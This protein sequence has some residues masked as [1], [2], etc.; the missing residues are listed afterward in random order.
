M[1][2]FLNNTSDLAV[3]STTKATTLAD[4]T[5]T[6]N[7]K[8]EGCVSIQ[9]V[10]QPTSVVKL[11]SNPKQSKFK[12]LL[13][14]LHL[15][16][17]KEKRKRQARVYR[18]N[19]FKKLKDIFNK[20]EDERSRSMSIPENNDYDFSHIDTF[21]PHNIPNMEDLR[22]QVPNI[23][24]EF[25]LQDDDQLLVKVPTPKEITDKMAEV[26]E[27][28][29]KVAEVVEPKPQTE[30]VTTTSQKEKEETTY[31]FTIRKFLK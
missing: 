29:E 8:N 31:A 12:K 6:N 1:A 7:K 4:V 28:S 25:G 26:K 17:Y 19:P 23:T 9:V 24:N 21:R 11:R 5:K 3:R 30:K 18:F 2:N 13:K 16:S 22:N 20:N 10:S 14:K 15:A 27:I